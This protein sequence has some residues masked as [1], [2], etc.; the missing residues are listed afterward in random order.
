M[1]KRNKNDALPYD[2][3]NKVRYVDCDFSKAEFGVLTIKACQ[4]LPTKFLIQNKRIDGGFQLI[5]SSGKF[6]LCQ[7]SCF[8]MFGNNQGF[9]LIKG[10]P[11]EILDFINKE[12][13]KQKD[14]LIK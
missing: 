4:Q 8:D 2:F 13:L 14:P 11:I 6:T 1:S 10:W 7:I 12:R 9:P 3:Y 5:N